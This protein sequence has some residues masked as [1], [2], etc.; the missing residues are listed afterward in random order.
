MKGYFAYIRVSTVKQGEHGSSLQEQ[1]S[2]IEA[3][4]E[5]QKLPISTWFEEK[6]TA[7]KQGRPV[8]SRMIGALEKGDAR[9]IIIHKID[10]SARNLKD[11]ANLGGLIDRGIDVR[12]AH[13]SMDLKTRGGRLAADIQA[14][15]AA[16]YIRNL[17][18]EVLKGYYGRLKQGLYPLPA[19]IGY[20]DR[21]KGKP[22]DIDPI[23]GPL[24]RQAFDLYATGK[25]GLKTLQREMKKRA[26]VSGRSGKALSLSGISKMLNNTFYTGLIHIKRTN[27]TFNGVHEPLITK[28]LFDRVQ[29][30][31]KGK[32]VLRFHKHQ[33]LFRRLVRCATCGYHLIGERQKG[34]Y[35]YYRCHSDGCRGICIREELLDHAVQSSLQYLHLNEIEQKALKEIASGLCVDSEEELTRLKASLG[36]QIG[37]CEERLARLTDA[38]LDQTIEK[39][40]FESRKQAILSERRL[41]EDKLRHASEADIPANAALAKLEL[42]NAAYL[43][44]KNGIPEEKRNMLETI[45]S[46]FV[47]RGKEPAFT[48]L[49]PLKEVANW[50]KFHLGAPRRG[51]PRM[52]GKQLMDIVLAVARE[53]KSAVNDKEAAKTSA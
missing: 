28:S 48:L 19:P 22:K 36:L 27:E 34:R 8:F 12:F 38:Y 41:L 42:G 45:T 11:W 14:V 16:D 29:A 10:R 25:F 13:E 49:S 53:E 32:L 43:G 20:L 23:R 47:V 15:V 1:K 37:K 9:G 4:A 31:L 7:A 18:D 44:Y 26:L 17:R 52:R 24:V 33:Y 30:I 46:N 3:Y 51:D 5:R 6:E 50:Q 21:G 40:L 39:E 2:A 35:V